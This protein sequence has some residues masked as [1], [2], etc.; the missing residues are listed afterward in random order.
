M[1]NNDYNNYNHNN[2]HNNKK[3]NHNNNENKT[4][5]I[6]KKISCVPLYIRACCHSQQVDYSY[7]CFA[8]G[9]DVTNVVRRSGE[10]FISEEK[11]YRINT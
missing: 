2:N 11:N 6:I 3:N 5:D 7:L 10:G 8:L 4:Y 1:Q 9:S